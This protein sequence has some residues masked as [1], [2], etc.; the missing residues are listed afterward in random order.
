MENML[1]EKEELAKQFREYRE[2]VSKIDQP[3]LDLIFT[4]MKKYLPEQCQTA[5][6]FFI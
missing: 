3:V 1:K 2:M 6:D 5:E 4:L